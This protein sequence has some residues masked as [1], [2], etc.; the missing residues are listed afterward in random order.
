M[1]NKLSLRQSEAFEFYYSLG[2]A[3]TLK[4][5][6]NK[7]D[8]SLSTVQKWSSKGNWS[9]MVKDRDIEISKKL[10]ENTDTTI[11]EAKSHYLNVISK[12][13]TKYEEA[14]Q[15][16]NIKINSVQDLEKLAKLEMFLREKEAPQ[17]DTTV[18]IIFKRSKPRDIPEKLDNNQ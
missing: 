11:I 10:Q 9:K 14:L 5:V 6:C 16:G 3:R 4:Q 13:L 17:E 1:A 18:N 7:F 2:H 12:T 8:V 15:S